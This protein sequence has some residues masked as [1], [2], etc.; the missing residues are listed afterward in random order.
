M[1]SRVS[2]PKTRLQTDTAHCSM[3]Q[4]RPRKAPHQPWQRQAAQTLHTGPVGGGPERC[5]AP[6]TSTCYS[7]DQKPSSSEENKRARRAAGQEMLGTL[8]FHLGTLPGAF[9]ITQDSRLEGKQANKRYFVWLCYLLLIL[10][11]SYL[12]FQNL[13]CGRNKCISSR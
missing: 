8:C 13:D 1:F 7:A 12:A 11:V 2:F 4:Q 9:S 6:K 10:S 5:L 3:S